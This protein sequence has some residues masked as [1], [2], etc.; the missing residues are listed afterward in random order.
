MAT[1]LVKQSVLEKTILNLEKK[2]ESL[3]QYTRRPNL[4]IFGV[5]V[6]ENESPA[7]VEN[8]VKSLIAECDIGIDVTSLDRMHRV[9][10]KTSLAG[11]STTETQPI[12]VRFTSFRDRTKF[13]KKRKDIKDRLKLGVSLDLTKVRYDLLKEA[14]VIVES[15]GHIRFVYADVN[16]ELRAFTSKGKHIKFDSI[17]DLENISI[18]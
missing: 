2:V 1:L 8:K 7:S 5:P 13:Y 6:L 14:R 11:V 9:G 16:C 10:K 17:E 12:I 4:R 15:K 3:E 18:F